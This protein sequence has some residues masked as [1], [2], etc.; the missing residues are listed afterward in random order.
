MNKNALPLVILVVLLLVVVGAIAWIFTAKEQTAS[1]TQSASPDVASVAT[2]GGTAEL[3][4]LDTLSPDTAVAFKLNPR[5]FQP[6]FD[7]FVDEFNKFSATKV[8]QQFHVTELIQQNFEKGFKESE[9]G[10]GSDPEESYKKFQEALTLTKETWNDLDE[11]LTLVS[12]KTFKAGANLEIPSVLERLTFSKEVTVKKVSSFL[13]EKILEGKSEIKNNEFSLTKT[14][15][16][17]YK[18]SA[19][20]P[21]DGTT[22]EAGLTISG[23]TLE[24]TVGS[25]THDVFFVGAGQ[26]SM[27]S[28]EKWRKIAATPIE[29][30]A[31]S[32]Y[33]DPAKASEIVISIIKQ[34]SAASGSPVDA[35]ALLAMK[36]WQGI[37]AITYSSNFVKGLNARNCVVVGADTDLGKMYGKLFA[38]RSMD[39]GKLVVPTL[40]NSRTVLGGS[41]SLVGA[42]SALK[43]MKDFYAKITPAAAEEQK[44]ELEKIKAVFDKM[45]KVITKFGFQEI[46]AVLNA[47]SGIP[48][49]EV[50]VLF[51]RGSLKDEALLNELK[52]FID[53]LA[54][55][56]VT[57]SS[58]TQGKKFL[59]I[60][61]PAEMG[62]AAL[63]GGV[64]QHNSFAAGMSEFYVDEAD[65]LIAGGKSY[66]DE[67]AIDPSSILH[68]LNEVD[69]YLYLNT[70]PA[71][72]TAKP[73]LPMAAGPL[74]QQ[75][76]PLG[77]EDVEEGLNLLSGAIIFG[78]KTTQI[79]NQLVCSDSSIMSLKAKGS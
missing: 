22:V 56:M 16:T 62:G 67:F 31:V 78:Q 42:V 7:Y 49:P 58:D 44:A 74:E 11:M 36:S 63:A 28:L 59:Q 15:D 8:W 2:T 76:L 35:N 61:N 1:I 9:A 34:G 4:L 55:G 77:V 45:E 32:L 26:P 41:I 12:G 30:A 6:L 27:G 25:A 17:T 66:F 50:G 10:K 39:K 64:V 71:I 65:K 69:Y 53:G 57:I 43:Y 79:D 40:M 38:L 73:F 20:N 24:L 68:N 75:G 19:K 47:P 5:N 54:P 48:M 60:G 23:T 3:T 52:T 72:M 13:N 21:A 14:N 51:G 70:E 37:E 29:Q 33:I 46:G 18:V